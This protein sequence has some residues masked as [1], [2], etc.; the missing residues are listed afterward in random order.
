[1][2]NYTLPNLKIY[3]MLL[4][5]F[6]SQMLFLTDGFL[7]SDAC[8]FSWCVLKST[9]NSISHLCC[10][11]FHYTFEISNPHLLCCCAGRVCCILINTWRRR[12]RINIQIHYFSISV[13]F[14]L[15]SCLAGRYFRVSYIIQYV[16][17]SRFGLW[18]QGG[19]WSGLCFSL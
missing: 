3:Q 2:V 11:Y 7:Y 9:I 1:M 16:R 13:L 10:R 15:S 5:I 18:W 14:C 4:G 19:P 8:S 17:R 12:V 6:N